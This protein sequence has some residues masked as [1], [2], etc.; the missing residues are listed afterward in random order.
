VS[1]LK[2]RGSSALF[3]CKYGS[4]ILRSLKGMAQIVGN[5]QLCVRC[6]YVSK[7]VSIWLNSKCLI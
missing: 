2:G 4:E 3:A 6:E 5:G 1:L 7:N